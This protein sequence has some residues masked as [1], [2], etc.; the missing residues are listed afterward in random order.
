MQYL[1]IGDIVATEYCGH[2]VILR[3]R[4]NNWQ[5]TEYVLRMFAKKVSTARSLY[6]EFVKKGMAQGKRPEL[7]GGG[8]VRSLGGWSAV[9]ALRK[10]GAYMKGDERILGSGDFV[11]GILAQAKE[12]LELRGRKGDRQ[13]IP[14][15]VQVSIVY[16]TVDNCFYSNFKTS[17]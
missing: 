8:L 15:P 12:D 7:V 14:Y 4:K 3:K 10:V 13:I 5:N 16:F 6:R 11:E 17:C 2:A 9:K 1:L